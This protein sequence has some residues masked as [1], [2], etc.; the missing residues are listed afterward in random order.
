[1]HNQA[2]RNVTAPDEL[3]FIDRE[4]IKEA[5]MRKPQ[6]RCLCSAK[7]KYNPQSWNRCRSSPPD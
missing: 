5:Q 2:D 3:Q 6:S 7:Q 4:R 1:V